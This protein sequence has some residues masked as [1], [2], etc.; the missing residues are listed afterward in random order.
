MSLPLIIIVVVAQPASPKADPALEGMLEATAEGLPPGTRV[1]LGAPATDTSGADAVVVLRWADDTHRRARLH[2]ATRDGR[3]NDRELVFAADDPHRERGRALG[4]ATV[5]IIPEDLRTPEPPP[6]ERRAEPP[7]A[8][9]TAPAEPGAGAAERPERPERLWIDATAQGTTGFVGSAGA[10]GGG[11][12]AR[13]PFGP[14]AVRAGVA[15]R[16][17]AVAEADASSLMLRA[18]VGLGFW[19]VV[20]DPRLT[21][22]ARTGFVLFRHVLRPTGPDEGRTAGTHTLLGTEAVA[23]ASWALGAR[24][25]LIGGGGAEIAFGKTRVLVGPSQVSVIPPF[26]IV[27]ELGARVRF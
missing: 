17:G 27:A 12:A 4:Y 24:L 22:G 14:I 20:L 2:I 3:E 6:R 19:T 21:V 9:L 7:P 23:E 25:S 15:A 18:D 11:L 13:V 5:A 8:P 1:Q 10:I 26:R 16:A